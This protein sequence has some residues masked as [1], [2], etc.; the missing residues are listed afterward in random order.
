M[1]NTTSNY[2]LIKPNQDDYFN[3][4]DF[5]KNADVIDGVLKEQK[6]NLLDEN[7]RIE[8]LENNLYNP[9]LLINSNFKVSALVNQR[10]D[11]SYT[12]SGYMWDMW[13][14]RVDGKTQYTLNDEYI[15]VESVNFNSHFGFSQLIEDY[16]KLLGQTCTLT[17][18]AKSISD[19]QSLRFTIRADETPSNDRQKDIIL[20]TTMQDYSFTFKVQDEINESLD[21]LIFGFVEDNGFDVEYV[22]LEIG[23]RA[24]KFVDDD[25]ATKLAKC[26]RYLMV[27]NTDTYLPMSIFNVTLARCYLQLP[28]SMRLKVPTLKFTGEYDTDVS[29]SYMG[30]VQDTLGV[31]TNITIA[32]TNNSNNSILM[33]LSGTYNIEHL[34]ISGNILIY[35][36]AKI[37][38]S[39]EL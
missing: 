8:V 35:N 11:S 27:Y 37:I 7:N 6:D 3:V 17:V 34:G 23:S 14:S 38:L 28:T 21:I 16:T 31:I 29:L 10:G 32:G 20:D 39:A 15:R 4:E 1:S 22:K 2:G 19:N 30:S 12:S 26:Q 18:R 36:G 9:N 5:N 33:Q 13:K 25:P 24:T